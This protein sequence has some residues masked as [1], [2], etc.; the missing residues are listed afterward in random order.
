V[1]GGDPTGS[2]NQPGASEPMLAVLD[3]KTGYGGKQVLD[4]ASLQVAQGE[5]VALLG[6]NGAGKSTLLKAAF[7]LIPI[8]SGSIGFR[9]D[10]AGRISP[11]RR[12]REGMAY[13]PQGGRC[14]AD[15]SVVENLEVAGLVLRDRRVLRERRE[16]AYSLFPV[17]AERRKQLA[18]RLSGGE[19][20]ML[21][22]GR[23]LMVKPVLLLVDEPSLGLAP[24]VLTDVLETIK[25]LNREVGLSVLMVEQNV[26]AALA[27]SNRAYV[28]RLGR[29]VLEC[30]PD[31][32]QEEL[33][34]AFLG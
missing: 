18:G 27:V 23:A 25:R 8:W 5:I 2:A 17:L 32:G 19:R 22:L 33:R 24:Q 21:A 16:R 6:P 20:Q 15:M 30:G 31:V 29:V 3:L 13:V 34:R 1:S 12:V 4:G 7:G 9:S 14:F 26:R 28:L 11:E 10:S